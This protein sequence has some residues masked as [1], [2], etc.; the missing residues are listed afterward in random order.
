MINASYFVFTGDM[1]EACSDRY[2]GFCLHII[3]LSGSAQFM[4]GDGLFNMVANEVM[5]KSSA[6]PVKNLVCSADLKI[7]AL[8]ISYEYLQSNQPQSSYSV[9]GYLSTVGN[10]VYPV[11]DTDVMQMRHDFKEIE[12]RLHQ[13]YN[14]FIDDILRHEVEL[15]IL[16]FY[17]THSRSLGMQVDGQS[18]SSEILSRFV[19]LLSRGLYKQNRHVS[20]YASL[21]FITPKY[22]SEACLSASGNNA[23]YWIDYFT[24]DALAHELKETGKPLQQIADEYHFSSVSYFSRYVKEHLHVAPS[25]LRK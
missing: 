24:A 19:S 5:I 2:A 13:P 7:E 1:K 6:K 9:R 12:K 23:S 8:L 17:D 15:M 11:S 4:I 25:E 10:P 20:Y 14:N 16:D 3:C 21:L 18:R 22:L